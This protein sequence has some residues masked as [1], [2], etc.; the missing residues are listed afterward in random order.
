MS[1]N[2]KYDDTDEPDGSSAEFQAD[3]MKDEGITEWQPEE[4]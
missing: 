1:E 4:V 2:K 3:Q